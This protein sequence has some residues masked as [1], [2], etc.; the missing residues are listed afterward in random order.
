MP[1]RFEE[2]DG[3]VEAGLKRIGGEQIDAALVA[4]RS[5]E[6][7]TGRIVHEVRR[8]GKAVR[9]LIR[10]VRPEF[11]AFDGENAAFR[12]I[13][14]SISG[15]R[16]SMVLIDTLDALA[17][18]D[19][20]LDPDAVRRLRRRLAQPPEKARPLRQVL[21]ECEE[22]LVA[23]RVRAAGWTLT[24]D[25]W[26]AIGGG[27]ARTLKAARTAMKDLAKTGDPACS[28]E[29]RKQ[30]KYHAHHMRLLRDVG[31]G[32]A[33]TRATRSMALADMLGERHDLDVFMAMLA[34]QPRRRGD[35]EMLE[36]LARLARKRSAKLDS[37][38]RKLGKDLFGEKPH[39]LV[40][41]WAERWADR[42]RQ[43][44]MA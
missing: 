44:E 9:A 24:A 7:E 19:D 42:A 20:K 28:H 41:K 6:L 3:T 23:A 39:K 21:D 10:L 22:R 16:D 33:Q 36:R 11:A 1:F 25:D 5:R 35:A 15:A 37:K 12:D 27:F 13:G 2:A 34:A 8:R 38:A 40:G 31:P 4:I 32:P 30:V 17:G 43:E 14:R 26:Q 29:W 18:E